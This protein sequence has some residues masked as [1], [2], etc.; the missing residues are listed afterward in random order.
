MNGLGS[1]WTKWDLQVATRYY[2]NYSG[3]SLTPSD[4]AKITAVTGL[5]SAQINS[6]HKSL[7]DEEYAKLYVEYIA[8]LTDISVVAIMN[9]N[10]GKGIQ[11]VRDYLLKRRVTQGGRYLEMEIFPGVE[12]GTSDK[13]HS[14][15]VFNPDSEHKERFTYDTNGDRLDT[16][17]WDDYIEKFLDAIKIANPRFSNG[18]KPVNSTSLNLLGILNLAD[19]W[20][21]IPVMP[22][23]YNSDGCFKELQESNR[24][25]VYSNKN[26]GIVD[27]ASVGSNTALKLILTGKDETFGNKT[28][29]QIHTSDAQN[30]K[31][32]GSRFTWIKSETSFE[33]LKQ[34]IYEPIERVSL[35]A[36]NPYENNHKLY[37]SKFQLQGGKSFPI[38]EVEFQLNRELIAIIGGRGSG[39]STLLECIA[40]LNEEHIKNDSNGKPKIIEYSRINP[41]GLIPSPYFNIETTIVDKDKDNHAYT[42]NIN[43]DESLELPFLYI[44]QE[45]LSSIATND[46]ELTKR[47]CDLINLKSDLEVE[48]NI[49]Q[50]ASE[51]LSKIES[52]E[53]ELEKIESRYSDFKGDEFDSWIKDKIEKKKIQFA[54]LTSASTQ[55]ILKEITAI[56]DKGIKLTALQD[57]VKQF[58]ESIRD[59]ALNSE[60]KN[61]NTEIRQLFP[62]DKLVVIPEISTTEIESK[63]KATLDKSNE[64]IQNLRAEYLKYK[65][66]LMEKGIKEDVATLIQSAEQIQKEI[67]VLEMDKSNHKNFKDSLGKEIE[68]RNA[69]LDKIT[70]YLEKAELDL[71]NGFETFKTSRDESTDE[72]KNNFNILIEGIDIKGEL[73]LN[74]DAFI[75]FLLN[76]CLDRRKFSNY[77][78]VKIN[79]AGSDLKDNAK[80]IN[81][82]ALTEWIK[83]DIDSLKRSNSFNSRGY[84][85][86]IQTIFT[87]WQKFVSVKARV[88]LDSVPT[89]R[90]SI[91]QR[92]T[93]LLKIYLATA[94]AKEICIIDQPEDNLDNKFIMNKLVPLLRRL[95]KS[96]QIIISTHNANLVVNT[97]TEQVIV[98]RLDES[99]DYISGGIENKDINK[100]MKEIL[101]GG[102]DAFK[103]R[104]EKYYLDK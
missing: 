37:F 8:L 75:K 43:E 98:A 96:R 73:L 27:S 29:A 94:N 86:L 16:I 49:T 78:E 99:K 82:K 32:I 104:R 46:T 76:E 17:S 102:E 58:S 57:K 68:I 72:E 80:D 7:T 52:F 35:Q 69:I 28:V 54:R 63:S 47:V 70:S 51:I 85:I 79:I 12:I 1:T 20:D 83:N 34:I 18:H 87:E 24:I 14:L 66:E 91:G 39:K 25:E 26:F 89:D 101:E 30:L 48:S 22:H 33:G 3:I 5:T 56:T 77:R 50:T 61:I 40:M 45:Q 100:S 2:N 15:I 67:T 60:I 84:D 38:Q 59:L 4:T 93:L 97:D 36:L 65:K 9:H 62:D 19:E 95:K 103:K 23:I 53:N 92:G 55:S 13:C 88:T 81:W 41:D 74:Q 10:T 11:A 64:I 42:K 44:G 71:T 6:N 31:E 90:L 21:F